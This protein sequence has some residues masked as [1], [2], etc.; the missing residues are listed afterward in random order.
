M[1]KKATTPATR[2]T[3]APSLFDTAP[4]LF[5]TAPDT[6]GFTKCSKPTIFQHSDVPIGKSVSGKI[7]GI[8][9]ATASGNTVPHLHLKHTSGVEFLFP[10]TG[11]VRRSLVPG[12]TN[13][14][15][16]KT[17]LDKLVDRDFIATR[18]PNKEGENKNSYLFEVYL[19]DK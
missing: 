6:K 19:S 8:T 16:L 13:E 4:S 17:K 18:Q 10:V 12:K 1:S 2:A 5:D 15:E 14:A 11:A 3:P 9:E 7:I